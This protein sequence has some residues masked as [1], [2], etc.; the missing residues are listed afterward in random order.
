MTCF[1]VNIH[2]CYHM[3]CFEVNIHICYHMTCFKV[4]IH[5][6]YHMTCFEVTIHICYHM[7]C[8]EVNIH[9]SYHMT[10]FEVN[11][12][13]CYHQGL[14]YHRTRRCASIMDTAHRQKFP[15]ILD[16]NLAKAN[17]TGIRVCTSCDTVVLGYHMPCFDV[18]IHMCYHMTCNEVI[19]YSHM[20]S[21]DFS[22]KKYVKY[23]KFVFIYA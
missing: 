15:F 5:I 9:I 22:G 23:W 13:I 18:N 6:C 17:C 20:L 10:C 12:H 8:F 2:I 7:T 14:L 21:H 16:R 4:N 19:E 3:T 11:I 1:E